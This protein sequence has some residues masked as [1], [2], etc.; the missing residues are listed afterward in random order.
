MASEGTFKRLVE[1]GRVVLVNEGPFKGKLAAIVEIQD[2][3][4]VSARR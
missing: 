3:S 2:A 4:R 1:N